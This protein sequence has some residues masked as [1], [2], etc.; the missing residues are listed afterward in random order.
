MDM[1]DMYDLKEIGL[2][3]KEER[4]KQGISIGQLALISGV[5]YAAI[6]QYEQGVR[7]INFETFI[8]VCFVLQIKISDLFPYDKPNDYASEQFEYLVKDLNAK[9]I[10]YIFNTVAIM[11]AHNEKNN[12]K[13]VSNERLKRAAMKNEESI[14]ALQQIAN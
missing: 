7:E 1:L 12:N 3:L 8:K 9:S 14:N 13:L 10:H 6:C 2:Q 5:R 4:I 11:V